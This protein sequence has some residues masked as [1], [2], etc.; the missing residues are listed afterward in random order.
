MCAEFLYRQLLRFDKLVGVGKRFDPRE[1]A[2]LVLGGSTSFFGQR[3][4]QLLVHKYKTQVINLD[5]YDDPNSHCDGFYYYIKC[6]FTSR[7]SVVKAV[8]KLKCLDVCITIMI[9]NVHEGLQKTNNDPIKECIDCFNANLVNIMVITKSIVTDIVPRDKDI[10]IIN[11]ATYEIVNYKK[12]P[13]STSYHITQAG[14]IQFHDGLSSELELTQVNHGNCYKALLVF[15]PVEVDKDIEKVILE[16]IKLLLQGRRGVEY[17]YI[18]L[19]NVSTLTFFID[20]LK[21]LYTICGSW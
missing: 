11:I 17:I 9:N 6:D 16:F 19:L 12:K 4:C 14:L 3:L 15:I 18:S 20:Y 21:D 5:R 8:K 7:S 2:I 13:F 1:D 10:Y